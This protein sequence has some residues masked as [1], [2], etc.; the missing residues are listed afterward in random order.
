VS[1]KNK[2]IPGGERIKKYTYEVVF[3][4]RI[5]F[6]STSYTCSGAKSGFFEKYRKNLFSC[7]GH[8][9][10][11]FRLFDVFVSFGQQANQIRKSY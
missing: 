7:S 8:F 6:C 5:Y 9:D 1:G 2:Q 3:Y 10:H 4:Y 11:F